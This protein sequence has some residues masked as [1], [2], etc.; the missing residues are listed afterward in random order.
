[1]K[2]TNTQER[3]KKVKIM[4][5]NVK[6]VASTVQEADGLVLTTTDGDTV[7]FNSIKPDAKTTKKQLAEA[8]KLQRQ[9]DAK[10]VLD[11]RNKIYDTVKKLGGDVVPSNAKGFDM[12]K[13]GGHMFVKFNY[14][15][16]NNCIQV[17]QAVPTHTPDGEQNHLF[18]YKY[19]VNANT[20]NADKLIT[21]IL[22]NAIT[23]QQ[24]KNK[25]RQ[26]K[27]DAEAAKKAKKAEKVA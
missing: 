25:A 9:A 3:L 16:K 23:A 15:N 20:K 8:T 2:T 7:K 22:T 17:R 27:A 14:T 13:V 18:T 4:E 24:N 10:T 5:T 1:L 26:E 19:N 12:F 21:D 11:L 6:I